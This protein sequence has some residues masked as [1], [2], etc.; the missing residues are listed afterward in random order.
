MV[1][2]SLV[3]GIFIFYP[4]AW[5]PCK[6]NIASPLQ[7]DQKSKARGYIDN[8][9]LDEVHANQNA[10]AISLKLQK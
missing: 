8:C 7:L 9:S 1:K 3:K 10:S 6:T 5:A 2:T 4:G